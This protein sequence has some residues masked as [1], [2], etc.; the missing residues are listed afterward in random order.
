M[1][2]PDMSKEKLVKVYDKTGKAH[3]LSKLNAI[4]AINHNGCVEAEVYEGVKLDATIQARKEG[5]E[6]AQALQE[7]KDKKADEKRLAAAKD[8]KENKT[9]TQSKEDSPNKTSA[10]K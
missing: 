5:R 9:P 8:A 10:S 2:P 4:D 6:E 3:F 1:R 7:E